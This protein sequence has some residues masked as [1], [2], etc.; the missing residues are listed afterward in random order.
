MFRCENGKIQYD[1]NPQPA[2]CNFS[3]KAELQLALVATE[4]AFQFRNTV[5]PINQWL[6]KTS[7]FQLASYNIDSNF[8]YNHSAEDEKAKVKAGMKGIQEKT[9]VKFVP[10]TSEADY[11]EFRKDPQLGCGAMVGRRPGRG[12]PMAVNYQAPEC[13]QTTGTIQHELLH[14]LGLFHEQARPDRDNYV[15][16][17]WD[18]IIPGITHTC[19]W[20]PWAAFNVHNH[21]QC[22]QKPGNLMPQVKCRILKMVGYTSFSRKEISEGKE[23]T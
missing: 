7:N 6:E 8:I 11:I 13:L 12:F 19:A 14:V 15:T 10:H 21:G 2:L 4:T 16:V 23:V 17:L 18:N 9:C 20:K 22:L 5:V 3:Y 1:K